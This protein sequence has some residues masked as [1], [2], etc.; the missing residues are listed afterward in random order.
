VY[1]TPQYVERSLQKRPRIFTSSGLET[2]RGY[3]NNYS[4]V[5]QSMYSTVERSLQKRPRIFTSSGLE[6]KRG[7]NNNY[8]TVHHSMY[9][10]AKFAKTPMHFYFL[11]L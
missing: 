9:S 2:K 3:N 7:Y 6:T 5:H 10:R 8:S 4:T 11:W 1:C